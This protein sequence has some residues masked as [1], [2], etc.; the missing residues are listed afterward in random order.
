MAKNKLRPPIKIEIDEWVV[1]AQKAFDEHNQ[2]ILKIKI[3]NKNCTEDLVHTMP[4]WNKKGNTITME[5]TEL[6]CPACSALSNAQEKGYCSAE[7]HEADTQL[8][9]AAI[10]VTAKPG[11][12]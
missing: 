2:P 8:L 5:F 4:Q 1:S 11:G 6:N 7:C 10:V 12:K 3:S 9:P